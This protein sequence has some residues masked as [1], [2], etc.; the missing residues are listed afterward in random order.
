MPADGVHL[1]GRTDT[2]ERDRVLGERSARGDGELIE[3]YGLVGLFEA[4]DERAALDRRA[5]AYRVDPPVGVDPAW[6]HVKTEPDLVPGP[7][8]AAHPQVAVLRSHS[9]PRGVIDGELG[10]GGPRRDAERQLAGFPWRAEHADRHQAR[11][12]VLG[13]DL[14]VEVRP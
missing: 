1:D 12:R 5:A 4:V 2:V 10:G 8:R 11:P 9:L 13:V 7:P 6:P 3:P 14:D